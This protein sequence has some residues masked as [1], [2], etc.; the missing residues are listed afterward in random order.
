MSYLKMGWRESRLEI[1]IDGC[2]S[3]CLIGFSLG[4]CWN[5]SCCDRT[6]SF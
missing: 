6:V 3:I 1:A 2:I 5:D 4:K